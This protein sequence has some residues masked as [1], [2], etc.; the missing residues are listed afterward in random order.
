MAILDTA[1]L[2]DILAKLPPS[3]TYYI[4]DGVQYGVYQ[5]LGT[6]KMAAQPHVTPAVEGHR[7]ADTFG[8]AVQAY[9]LLGYDRAFRS[10]VF[11]IL[12]DIKALAPFDTGNLRNSYHVTQE[13]P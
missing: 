6:S 3:I 12:A 9:G 11:T 13:R 7:N 8:R 10:F 4:A 2:D 5:E 1:V